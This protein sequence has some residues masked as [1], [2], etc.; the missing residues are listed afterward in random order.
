MVKKRYIRDAIHSFISFDKDGIENKLI[1]TEEFQRLK[2]IRQLGLSYFTYPSALHSRFSHSLGTYWLSNRMSDILQIDEEHKKNLTIAALLHDIGHGPFSH[3]LEKKIKSDG[4]HAQITTELIESKDYEISEILNDE[5]TNPKDI[6]EILA[7]GAVK[8]RYL[9]KIISSQLDVDRFDYLLR[10]SLMSGNP[11][12]SFDLER[13]IQTIK[14]NKDKDEIYVSEGGWWAVEHYLNCRYQMHKQVYYH[15]S[16]L[17]AEELIKKI[18]DR[19]KIL[20]ENNKIKLDDKYIPLMKGDMNLS[21]FLGFTDFDIL[22]LLRAIKRNNDK[23]LSDLYERFFKRKLFKYIKL[24]K[25]EGGKLFDSKEKIFSIIRKM[26]LD[27]NYYFSYVDLSTTKAYMPYPPK[28]KDEENFIF[29]NPECTKEIS[30]QIPSLAAIEFQ[31]EFLIYLP[32]EKCREEV[33]KLFN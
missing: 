27:E 19:C 22:S 2:Y 26:G 18:I 7:S 24:P 12:G 30:Q 25:D 29:I 11:H 9:H 13:V 4:S 3:A 1:D 16:T 21:E 17:A 33:R 14:I 10:D 8:P 20:F 5:G 28:P 23:I 6:S 15:H 31:G 32:N